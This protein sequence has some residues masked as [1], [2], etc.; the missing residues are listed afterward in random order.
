MGSLNGRFDPLIERFVSLFGR[1][2][3]L[4]GHLGNWSSITP[5]YQRV[6]DCF[7]IAERS[8]TCCFAVSSRRAGMMPEACR[9]GIS[10]GIGNA[11]VSWSTSHHLSGPPI[12]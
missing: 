6:M 5:Q 7:A 3:S 11:I 2:N 8:K 10:A 12:E 4:F 9:I 1:F